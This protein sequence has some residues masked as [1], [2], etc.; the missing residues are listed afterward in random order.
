MD[1]FT[2]EQNGGDIQERYLLRLFVTG[3]T[4]RS[5]KAIENLR[6]I[7]ETHLKGRYDLEVIDIY[8]QPEA[9]VENQVIAAPTLVKML[10]AP[11][12]RIIGDLSESEKILHSL[13]IT[14]QP[15]VID[16]TE[17]V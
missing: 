15:L 17:K 10:P 14:P 4:P 7:C 9:A 6:H 11:I 1:D 12:R 3:T 2:P 5:S 13:N 16:H 8:Q